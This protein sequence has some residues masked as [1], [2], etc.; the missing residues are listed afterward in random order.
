MKHAA[1]ESSNV[2]SI[3]YDEAGKTLE[4]TF[5]NG[6]TYAYAGVPRSEHEAL[7]NSP[8]KGAHLSARI[9]PHFNAVRKTQETL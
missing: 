4:V 7:T 5:K 6:V 8:S 1:V 3:G 9:K 2:Q